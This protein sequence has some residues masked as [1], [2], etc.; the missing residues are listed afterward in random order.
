MQTRLTRILGRLA[1][2]AIAFI[3]CLAPRGLAEPGQAVLERAGDLIREHHFQGGRVPSSAL[4]TPD[5]LRAYLSQLD[6][7][8]GLISPERMERIRSRGEA[9]KSGLGVVALAD[10]DR[11]LLV[12]LLGGAV[13]RAGIGNPQYLE[14]VDGM[15]PPDIEAARL[16]L[17]GERQRLVLT[18]AVDE[19]RRRITLAPDS[20]RPASVE[21]WRAR[22]Q[23][24]LRIHDF[25]RRQTVADMTL[26]LEQ[27][28]DQTADGPLIIDLR[29]ALGG[30]LGEAM[31]VAN[32]LLPP[33]P[34][35]AQTRDNRGEGVLFESTRPAVLPVEP[36]RIYVL[37]SRHTASSGEILAGAL[38]AAGATLVGEPTYGKCLAQDVFPLPE[39]W[40]LMLSTKQVL[41]A[42]GQYCDG[43]PLQ[44]DVTLPGRV[45]DSRA[46]IGT[47]LRL[48]SGAERS[49]AVDR[50]AIEMT[51]RAHDDSAPD[52]SE[53]EARDDAGSSGTAVDVPGEDAASPAGPRT[54]EA[55]ETEEAVRLPETRDHKGEDASSGGAGD[56]TVRIIRGRYPG[57]EAAPRSYGGEDTTPPVTAP[58]SEAETM[59]RAPD[60]RDRTEQDAEPTDQ[61]AIINYRG[62]K[63]NSDETDGNE[64]RL[65]RLGS[66]VDRSY[67]VCTDRTFETGHE[68]REQIAQCRGQVSGLEV[69]EL[70]DGRGCSEKLAVKE[71]AC[72]RIAILGACE[73]ARELRLNFSVHE[74]GPDVSWAGMRRLDACE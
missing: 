48:S 61:P 14:S 57:D 11:F 50:S 20:F 1:A 73:A 5:A 52:A 39:G 38:S 26:A 62:S 36:E 27:L 24:Y 6:D 18:D 42:R 29:Y 21:T 41:D 40:G 64:V 58:V 28:T 68:M 54:Q 63:P 44:P 37:I 10:A 46:L 70:I 34:A 23:T 30:D 67:R 16:A 2:A 55:T 56:P 53:E 9:A 13:H 69:F 72:A 45:Y 59:T 71:S 74:V 51:D 66:E 31:A 7:Y 65:E 35:L 15:R 17:G 32:R 22:G 3:V 4:E 8:S 60:V 33:G 25:F 19:T 47:V 12:P 43:E 49:A